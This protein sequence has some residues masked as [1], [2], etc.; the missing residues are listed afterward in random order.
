[1]IPSYKKLLEMES[2]A[3]LKLE[4]DKK[5]LEKVR[6]VLYHNKSYIEDKLIMY[7]KKELNME[8]FKYKVLDINEN[9]ADILVKKGSILFENNVKDKDFLDFDVEELIDFRKFDNKDEIII[10]DINYDEDIIN[11]GYLCESMEYKYLSY[12]NE[13]KE[14][15]EIFVNYIIN[16]EV[17]K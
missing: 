12:S 6:R 2:V 7:L 8:Y 14:R 15:L 16:K 17:H 11:L 13:I 9:I 5:A 1:M 3:K 10:L 4:Q